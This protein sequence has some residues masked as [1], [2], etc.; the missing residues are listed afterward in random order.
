M[1]VYVVTGPPAGGKTTW[2]MAHAGP[3][4]LVLDLD[5]LAVALAGPGAD[6]HRHPDHVRAVARA[7]RQAALAEAFRRAAD[8][9]V[10][11][12]HTDPGPAT[13]RQY[14]RAGVRIVTVDPGQDVVMRRCRTMRG[15]EAMA[16]AARWYAEPDKP[17]VTV[18]NKS[19]AW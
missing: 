15:R 14:R 9:D 7:A 10:Y 1:T 16:V 5:R 19:R 11:V 3:D 12:V 17:G 8:A 13:L 6:D 4:D 2:V 18:S